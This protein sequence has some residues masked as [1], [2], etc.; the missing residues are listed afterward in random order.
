[1][2]YNFTTNYNDSNLKTHVSKEDADVLDVLS[3]ND[4]KTKLKSSIAIETTLDSLYFE[5]QHVMTS[6]GEN[7]MIRNQSTDINFFP[8]WQAVTENQNLPSTERVYSDLQTQQYNEGVDYVPFR[9]LYPNVDS[10]SV[11]RF[12][13][14]SGQVLEAGTFLTFNVYYYNGSQNDTIGDEVFNNNLGNR[15][16]RK[17]L[18]V[19]NRIEIGDDLEIVF[20]SPVEVHAGQIIYDEITIGIDSKDDEYFLAKESTVPNIFYQ[21][22]KYKTFVDVPIA[23]LSDVE[24]VSSGS[25]YKGAYNA[26]LDSPALPTGSDENGDTYRVSVSGNGKE[27]GDL[28][29]YNTNSALY[30]HIPVKAVTQAGIAQSSLITF[31]IFVKPDY[32]GDVKNG[33]AY[34]PFIDIQTAI[35]AASDGDSIFVDGHCVITQDISIDPLKSLTFHGVKGRTKVGYATYDNSNG[36][37]FNQPNTGCTKIYRFLDLEV[38]NSGDYGIYIRSAK[39]VELNNNNLRNN[40]WDGTGLNTVVPSNISGVLG[41]DSSQ[42]EL[43]AFKNSEHCSTA[44]GA[45]RLR[46]VS[47]VIA[48]DN[49]VNENLRAL[50]FQDCGI[51]GF[52]FV[53]RN[54]VSKNI[55]SGIYLA[56]DSYT[57]TDG[58]ENF[59]VYNNASKYNANNGILSIGGIN[60]VIAL[61]HIEGNWNAGGMAWHVSNTVARDNYVLNNNRSEFNG[62]GNIGDAGASLEISGDTIRDDAKFIIHTIN[63]QIVDTGLGNSTT[64]NGLRLT[65]SLDGISDRSK[66]VILIDNN[67][68]QGQDYAY[69]EECNLDNIRLVK[70]DNTY[71]D[72][73][74]QDTKTLGT[75]DYYELPY[76]NQHTNANTLDLSLDATGSQVGIK[77]ADGRIINYYGVNQLRATAFGSKVR[78]KLQDS[79]KIQFDDVP[80][81]GISINGSLV[82]SVLSI[83]ITQINDL[84]T[85]TSG[86]ATGGNPVTAFALTGDDLTLT[87]QD[88]TSYTIDVT[89]LG[90]DENKFV[91]SGALNGSNLEL[92]MNDTSLITIDASNMINGATLPA[93]SDDWYIAYGNNAGDVVTYPSVVTDIKGKQPFYNGDL[94]EKGQEYIWTHEVGGSYILGIYS[95]A[96]ETSNE[97]DVMLNNK[98]ST[99][100]KFSSTNNTVRETSV[101]VDIASRYSNGYT[102]SNNTVLSLRYGNDNYL[103][104]FDISDPE[105]VLI[106]KSNTELVGES[107]IIF[108]GGDNQPNAKFPIMVKRTNTWTIVADFDNS[109]NNEWSDGIEPQT[110]IKSNLS[111]EAGYKFVW[112][113]P[114][115]GNNRYYGIGYTGANTGEEFPVDKLVGCWRWHTN[116]IIQYA[117]DW[118]LN[119][120]NSLYDDT[121]FGQPYWNPTDGNAITVSYRYLQDGTLEMWDEDR[122]ELIMT[123]DTTL[124][125]SNIHL[126]YGA[127]AY[128]SSE[129]IIPNLSIQQLGQG[130]QPITSFAPDISNQSFDVTKDQPFNVQIALDSGSDIVNQYAEEDAPNWAVLDQAT[131]YFNGN[132]PSTTGSHVINCKAA[133]AIGGSVNFQVTLNVVEPVYT[134]TKSLKFAGGVNSYLGGNAA[135][136]TALERNN[137]GSGDSEAW[138][139]AFWYKRTDSSNTGQTLFYFGNNDISNNGY[140]EV[141]Q[142]QSGKIRLKYGSNNNHIQLQTTNQPITTGNW[143]HVLISYN[144]GTTGSS[145]GSINNYYS[146]F[147]I[148]VNGVQ[149]GTANSQSNYGYTGSIV[150][151]NYRFGRLVSGNYPK[152]GLLNQ[153]AIWNSDQSSNVSG[154][155]NGGTSQ[156]ISLLQAGVGNMNTNYLFPDHYYEIEGSVTTIPDL[157]GNA[158][159]V[160]YNF[161]S[162]DLVDDA[163]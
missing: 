1:M 42:A 106:G 113:L 128:S 83:A 47:E 147:K 153:L 5:Q 150:G 53:S 161:S 63:N 155:Y 6:T 75:G 103:Y 160:G 20:E 96:T 59:V 77:D 135:L 107:Q 57:A 38:Y 151:Q 4:E 3:L 41:H 102:I 62:I 149:Q 67:T 122:G 21:E 73:A 40:C 92:T 33:S 143:C 105:P 24:S 48:I 142:V 86:F 148:F 15:I 10:S 16:Y 17:I 46:E 13:L 112:Q 104:L 2:P 70:G 66:A 95:G 72:S 126:Y 30:D 29:I 123:Y 138:T 78:I 99:N 35:N 108:F 11:W 154:L 93:R 136:V 44:G 81:S 87:L 18:Q 19:S 12:K 137:N 69:L 134:N 114:E 28:L 141:K 79:N 80:V 85:N 32:V 71:I 14:K 129:T 61:N 90:V 110:I 130:S 100:F 55:E 127:N 94:L 144:G 88:G 51:G 133:N 49:D 9:E 139:I 91:S 52:G 111:L 125:G 7:M 82:N 119:T 115:S 163:P 97:V 43:Q 131:G 116:E 34:T 84:F 145:S 76:S 152:D 56:S 26:D 117:Y 124:D 101:G 121:T 45:V 109:E 68:I 22:V 162:N 156:D 120:S 25:V 159:F 39:R 118:V 140:I 89:T 31:D 146:R 27:V 23:K 36:H 65:D 98:W 37:V 54:N 132:A 158:H 74:I 157:I 60:N 50:R 64:S 58:C 8:V